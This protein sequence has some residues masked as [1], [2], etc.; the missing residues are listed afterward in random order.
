MFAIATILAKDHM[1]LITGLFANQNKAK[2]LRLLESLDPL[3]SRP[4]VPAFL[5]SFPLFVCSW[6]EVAEAVHTLATGSE[7]LNVDVK[8]T[9]I[10]V[11]RVFFATQGALEGAVWGLGSK[12][13]YRALGREAWQL[14]Y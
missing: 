11:L 1:G 7:Q 4:P 9:V 10:M 2:F 3:P 5:P 6:G 13:A 14:D 8:A 12:S